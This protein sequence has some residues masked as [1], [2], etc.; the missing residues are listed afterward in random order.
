MEKKKVTKPKT[1][2]PTDN[3]HFGKFGGKAEGSIFED[4][5]DEDT[6]EDVPVSKEVRDVLGFDPDKEKW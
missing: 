3:I 4:D 5:A 6:D 1:K 2:K